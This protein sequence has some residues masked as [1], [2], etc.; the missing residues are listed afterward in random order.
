[1]KQVGLDLCNLSV[2]GG[3]CHVLGFIDYFFKWFE[4]RPMKDKSA[5]TVTQFLY[6]VI[7]LHDFFEIQINGQVPQLVTEV[8]AQISIRFSGQKDTISVNNEVLLVLRKIK[9]IFSMKLQQHKSLK[10]TQMIFFGEILYWGFGT[11]S[12]RK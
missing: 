9:M 8:N 3:C 1:M 5:T 6:V 2:I 7:C 12:A 11:K 4:V 10:L